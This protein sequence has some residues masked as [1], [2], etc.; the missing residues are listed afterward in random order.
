MPKRC[1]PIRQ[2]TVYK[3]VAQIR[4][5]RLKNQPGG[6]SISLQN[7]TKGEY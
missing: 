6:G 7:W 3:I 4:T 5:S 1:D 2:V